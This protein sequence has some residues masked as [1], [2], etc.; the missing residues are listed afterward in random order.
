[1]LFFFACSAYPVQSFLNTEAAFLSEHA[2]TQG[3][4]LGCDEKAERR[5]SE[6]GEVAP[7]SAVERPQSHS[8]TV[9]WK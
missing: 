1:M 5:R 2:E 4:A 3:A 9:T 7:G 6:R 8:Q